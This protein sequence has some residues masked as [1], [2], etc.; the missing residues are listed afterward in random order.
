MKR[1]LLLALVVLIA[2]PAMADTDAIAR[3]LSSGE[4]VMVV[5]H[6]ACWNGAPENSVAAIEACVRL[7]VDMIELDVRNTSDG[8]LVLLHDGTLDRTTDG[9]GP[10]SALRLEQVRALR[11]KDGGGGE[12]VLTEHQVPTLEEALLAARGRIMVNLVLKVESVVEVMHLLDRLGMADQ[13]LMKLRAEPSSARLRN[14]PFLG[15]THF[16]P[17]VG[18]CA[19]GGRPPCAME[20]EVPLAAFDLY[21]PVAYEVA[22]LG[23]RVFLREAA[24]S[25]RLPGARIW[26]NSLGEDD[27]Q[28]LADPEGVWGGLIR[29]GA[30]MI[31]TDEP[32]ALMKYLGRR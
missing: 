6:R 4:G 2:G 15:R 11:L 14:A 19:R 28:A 25:R 3:R 26:V 30:S 29:D 7:G 5:A 18:R 22:F 16:M 20:L 9:T 31:Q 24:G 23:D 27:R 17:I 32:E 10:L 13:V 8:A 1:L 12:A 21:R